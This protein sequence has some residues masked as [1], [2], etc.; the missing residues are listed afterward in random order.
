MS[1]QHGGNS[2]PRREY[3]WEMLLCDRCIDS[4]NITHEL[5]STNRSHPATMVLPDG[6]IGPCTD[7]FQ[8]SRPVKPGECIDFFMSH[9]WHDDAEA[10]LEALETVVSEFFRVHKRYPTFWLDKV[11]WHDD[12]AM[13]HAASPCYP[14]P[15][16]SMRCPACNEGVYKV[17]CQC[18]FVS[19][20]V[21]SVM[22]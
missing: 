18:R 5:M 12:A 20:K 21:T 15:T 3:L 1:D 16:P 22:A 8:L 10:K 13:I 2:S 7:L 14:G 9:S 11:N 6:S 4:A 17:L 19:T